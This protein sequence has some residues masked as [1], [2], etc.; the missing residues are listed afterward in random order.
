MAALPSGRQRAS[1]V[2]RA[3]R[4]RRRDAL[5]VPAVK[6]PRA[7]CGSVL[8][9]ESDDDGPRVAAHP[10]EISDSTMATADVWAWRWSS[11]VALLAR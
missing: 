1:R 10:I 9:L 5:N 3:S 2:G 7:A 11:E 6:R 8:A 4:E